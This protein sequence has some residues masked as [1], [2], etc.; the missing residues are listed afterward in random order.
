MR[1]VDLRRMGERL[2]NNAI[3]L[4]ELKK[5]RYLLFGRICIQIEAQ[6][7]FLKADRDFLGNGERSAKI[8]VAFGA[9]GRVAQ[10]N[11]ESSCD[12]AQSDAR[13][14]DQRLEQHVA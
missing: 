1:D 2:I 8:K 14:R 5:R 4:G 11:L 6:S 3:A 9:N 10:R 12:R 7:D 13:T